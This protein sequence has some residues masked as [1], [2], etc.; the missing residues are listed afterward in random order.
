MKSAL[1]LYGEV[2]ISFI[3]SVTP[4][5]EADDSRW[6]MVS[7]MVQEA[8]RVGQGIPPSAP[9]AAAVAGAVEDMSTISDTCAAASSSGRACRLHRAATASSL[10]EQT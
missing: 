1:R 8:Y 3:F 5:S 2:K 9:P 4:S 6:M 10:H 7:T